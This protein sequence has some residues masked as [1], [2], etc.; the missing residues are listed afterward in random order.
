MPGNVMSRILRFPVTRIIIAIGFTVAPVVVVQIPTMK[1]HLDKTWLGLPMAVVA[2]LAAYAGYRTYVHLLERR[3]P[4]ELALPGALAEVGGG[5]LLGVLL[6]S[7]TIGILAALGIYKVSG[8]NP[9]AVLTLPLAIAIVSGVFE[10]LIFRGILFRI[11]E[12]SLGSWVALLVSAVIFGLAH[13]ATPGANFAGAASIIIEAGILLAAAYMFTRRL[14]ICMG[15]HFAWNFTEAGVFG[16]DVSGRHV[17]GLLRSTLSG[18]TSL[19]GG[20]FGPEA[21]V[22]AIVLCLATGI[23]FIVAA[24]RRGHVIAP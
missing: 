9:V 20:T 24:V 10:E 17:D 4:A 11:V 13:L 3:T 6:F 2:A 21:S 23:A 16:T 12:E 1:W 19:T 14:W 22:V 7:V 15:L 5:V 8:V 18:P